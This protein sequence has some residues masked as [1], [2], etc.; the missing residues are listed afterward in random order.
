[1][2]SPRPHSIQEFPKQIRRRR[3]HFHKVM[4]VTAISLLLGTVGLP[5]LAATALALKTDAANALRALYVAHPEAQRLGQT[6]HAILVFPKIV[7][8]GLEF[9]GGYGEGVMTRNA[10]FAGYFN[11]VSA[12]W[13]WQAGAESYGYV[14]FL[15]NDKATKLLN[16]TESWEMGVGPNV[17]VMNEDVAGSTS[18]TTLQDDAYAFVF[19]QEGLMS[20][21]SVE[22]TKITQIKK[23]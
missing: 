9:G 5:A 19:N 6:A 18:N 11:S 1:M 17:V 8:A 12:S 21:L 16:Q 22:G 3:R 14:V 20:S 15:M 7:K 13:G 2:F 10:T 4:I 23:R